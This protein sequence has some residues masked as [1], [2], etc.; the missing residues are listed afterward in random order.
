V[1]IWNW[2]PNTG[3]KHKL[4]IVANSVLVFRHKTKA[5]TGLEENAYYR[6]W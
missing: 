6:T 5:V 3:Q 4:R 1:W 2:V